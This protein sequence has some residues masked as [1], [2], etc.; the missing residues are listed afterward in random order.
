LVAA[1]LRAAEAWIQDPSEAN[2]RAAREAAMAA[3]ASS[4][5][6]MA[7]TAAVQNGGSI[8]PPDGPE[9]LPNEPATARAVGRA[10][11]FAAIQTPAEKPPDRLSSFV[12]KGVEVA[13]G[14]NLWTEPVKT[15][16]HAVEATE[17]TEPQAATNGAT[18]RTDPPRLSKR[19]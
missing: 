11:T 18:A 2:R 1:A 14:A 19:A 5:A 16:P 13:T 17:G 10:L 12:A 4:P 15:D 6:G 8:G 3:G 9:I 7:A